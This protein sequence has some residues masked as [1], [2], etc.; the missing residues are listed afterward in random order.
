MLNPIKPGVL[1]ALMALL[2]SVC[3]A[4]AHEY[5]A[6]DLT[7][8]HPWIRATPAGAK[9]AGGYLTITNHGKETEA[10]VGGSA[11]GA[12]LFEIHEMTMADNLMKMRRLDAPLKIEPGQTL[13]L[14]P[15]GFH[16][17]LIGLNAPFREGEKIKGTLIF[18]KAGTVEVEFKVEPMGG[19]SEHGAPAGHGDAHKGH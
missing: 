1:G 2:A 13:E 19:R 6:G 18:E 10:F 16:L 5:K 11:A 9:T 12:E 3:L 15:G 8:G 14:K 17:M 4:S 7:I